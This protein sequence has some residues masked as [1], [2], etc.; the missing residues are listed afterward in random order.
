L[1]ELCWGGF[2]ARRQKS[3]L[4]GL[5]LP[6]ISNQQEDDMVAATTM[7]GRR[8]GTLQQVGGQSHRAHVNVGDTERWLSA[9]GGTVLTL[10]GL[11]RGDL[12]GLA[13]ALGG[14]ALIYRGL[15]GHCPCYQML[16]INT[17]PRSLKPAG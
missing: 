3:T 13:L 11:G 6:Q 4:I 7:T 5:S 2:S 8:P 15:S 17:A 9:V 10:F 12:P 1:L 14:G 16:G